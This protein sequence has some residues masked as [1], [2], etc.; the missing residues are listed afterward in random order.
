[1]STQFS[2]DFSSIKARN[3]RP[4]FF[5]PTEGAR[6]T[7]DVVSFR[8]GSSDDH[9]PYLVAEVVVANAE[10]GPTPAEVGAK[11]SIMFFKKY[12]STPRNVKGFLLAVTGLSEDALNA[13]GLK[14]LQQLTDT[15]QNP[16]GPLA[17]LSTPVQISGL[18]VQKETQ[19]KSK[20]L[21]WTFFPMDGRSL[22]AL[23][24][25]STTTRRR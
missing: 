2:Y 22:A 21:D 5:A 10:G 12:K 8:E 25:S 6:Y 18:A 4:P 20:I 13:D 3:P 24:A 9:G 14:I 19:N 17:G 16:G 23:Q 1:M 15:T 11:R 7:L